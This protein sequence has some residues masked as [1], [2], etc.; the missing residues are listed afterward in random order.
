M[1]GTATPAGTRPAD[2]VTD[3]ARRGQP[4]GVGACGGGAQARAGAHAG[5]TTYAVARQRSGR[6]G[7]GVE[8]ERGW[9]A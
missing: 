6:N 1:A 8:G 4:E 9:G 7:A 3:L 5:G 2:G